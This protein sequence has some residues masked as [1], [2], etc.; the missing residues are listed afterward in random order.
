MPRNR[1]A[2]GEGTV[3][4]REDTGRWVSDIP[5]GNGRRERV[6]TH[7]TERE[8]NAYR[9]KRLLELEA[10][11]TAYSGDMTAAAYLET[12]LA[13]VCQPTVSPVTYDSYRF[14]LS[15]AIRGF[16]RV[17]LD[18]LTPAR[19]RA[20]LKDAGT[21]LAPGSVALLHAI[22]KRAL[23]H[24]VAEKLIP[25]NPCAS[26]GRPRAERHEM[27]TLTE[28]ET[29]RL[30][31]A[32]R[33]TPLH[34]LY[35]LAV[36]TGLRQGELLALR[37]QDVDTE[38]GTVQV[39]RTVWHDTHN[40][41]VFSDPKT[42]R[43]RREI[44][45]PPATVAAL[46]TYRERAEPAAPGALLFHRG[47]APITGQYLRYRFRALLKAAGLPPIRFHDLRHTCATLLLRQGTSPK[48]VQELLGHSSVGITLDVY[49]HVV[50]SMQTDAL[51][52]LHDRLA[53]AGALSV[54][55]HGVSHGAETAAG[56]Q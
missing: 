44:R 5:L 37:W 24:A 12:W 39:R 48:V 9:R 50:P 33:E 4:Y 42:R 43:S 7:R 22:L 32:A 26:V 20:L 52:R 10:G 53:V 27:H 21:R 23:A 11:H 16:G 47:G 1:R 17:R 36:T 6:S 15:A 28:E 41:A 3:Y 8:A 2:P 25:E 51:E 31:A 46:R 45:L 38:A 29:A 30:L 34:C 35:L 55:S 13:D 19:I 18:A 49:S 54:Q 56:R 40:Q 14:T